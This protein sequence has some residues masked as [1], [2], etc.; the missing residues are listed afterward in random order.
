[1]AVMALSTSAL[2]SL[3]AGF[4]DVKCQ[5]LKPAAQ[6]LTT[7][8]IT[9]IAVRSAKTSC[10]RAYHQPLSIFETAE[11][12]ALPRH[13]AGSIAGLNVKNEAFL[14]GGRSP[15]FA[16]QNTGSV[17][18][19]LRRRRL[20]VTVAQANATNAEARSDD[21]IAIDGTTGLSA[22]EAG[23]GSSQDESPLAFSGTDGASPSEQTLGAS[24]H[25]GAG[26]PDEVVEVS[27]L[28]DSP[29]S[30]SAEELAKEL[31]A[32]GIKVGPDFSEEGFRVP[33]KQGSNAE[34]LAAIMA[35]NGLDPSEFTQQYE[36]ALARDQAERE[37]RGQLSSGQDLLE[38]YGEV[39][40]MDRRRLRGR[41]A[42]NKALVALDDA[43]QRGS[44]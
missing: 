15:L 9:S 33:D 18:R 3:P 2:G 28:D 12:C 21:T 10:F 1:V 29:N 26:F 38:Q 25:G 37:R 4:A 31:E 27:V 8:P 41:G 36:E 32:M 23:N 42:G 34:K 35:K 24:N 30:R 20:R 39:D 7:T 13:C 16:E 40:S 19:R 14:S 11:S 43:L 6:Q 44:R 22:V 5:L 17:R